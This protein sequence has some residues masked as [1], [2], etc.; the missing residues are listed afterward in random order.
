MVSSLPGARWL[1]PSAA[2][3]VLGLLNGSLGTRLPAARRDFLSAGE[4]S[5]CNAGAIALFNPQR[6][7]GCVCGHR[8]RQVSRPGLDVHVVLN[9]NKEDQAQRNG[10]TLVRTI[11]DL[12]ADM[13][14]ASCETTEA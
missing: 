13:A 1:H 5:A 8:I 14:G 3:A 7:H 2:L 12:R 10:R 6:T 11:K 4:G 9:N